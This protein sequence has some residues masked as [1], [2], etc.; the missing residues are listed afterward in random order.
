MAL[1]GYSDSVSLTVTISQ[2]GNQ[3][4]LKHEGCLT[5]VLLNIGDVPK[6]T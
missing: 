5:L 4:F 3:S 1:P 6:V 2:A